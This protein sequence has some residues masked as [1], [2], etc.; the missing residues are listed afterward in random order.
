MES[1]F[2]CGFGRSR[3]EEPSQ[4]SDELYPKIYE[5]GYDDSMDMRPMSLGNHQLQILEHNLSITSHYCR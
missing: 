4:D 2:L 1:P 5:E 3:P